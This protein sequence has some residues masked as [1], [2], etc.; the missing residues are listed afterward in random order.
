[1]ELCRQK[2]TINLS[3]PIYSAAFIRFSTFL[4][5][6]SL[7]CLALCSLVVIIFIVNTMVSSTSIACKP[8]QKPFCIGNPGMPDNCT[9]VANGTPCPPPGTSCPNGKPP[10][11]TDGQ[12][13]CLCQC[14]A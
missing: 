10:S 8:G 13:A 2:R 11:C 7:K 12:Y 5:V 3:S 9:C 4:H 1:M 14:S 6:M